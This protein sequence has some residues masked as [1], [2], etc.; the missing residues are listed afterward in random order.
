M[1]KK[2]ELNADSS[3]Q[4]L[5]DGEDV[6]KLNQVIVKT[7]IRPNGTLRIRH[8]FD[9]CP[10]MAEQHTAHE[11]N[12]NWLM[13]RFKPDELASYIAARAAHKKEIIGH[14]FSKEPNLQD[15][16][17][18]I[19][20]SKQ[21]F[22]ALPEE[23]KNNFKSHLEFLKFVDN[24]SNVEKMLKLGIITK[25]QIAEIKIPEAQTQPPKDADDVGGEGQKGKK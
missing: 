20:Q 5:Q 8:Y 19:Y 21:N 10:T 18:I 6:G 1:K 12:I 11:S 15:G 16:K 22:E 25:K 9:N 4:Q 13:K 7:E 2:Y 14:D 23:V 24:P 17:N 3:A